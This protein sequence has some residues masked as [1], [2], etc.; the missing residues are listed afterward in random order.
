MIVRTLI[1][2][3]AP[4]PASDTVDVTTKAGSGADRRTPE[5]KPG[6]YG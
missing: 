4:N 6:T 3:A 5:Q 2:L 1:T